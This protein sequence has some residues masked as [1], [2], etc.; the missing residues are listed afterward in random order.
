MK[1]AFVGKKKSNFNVIKMRGTTIKKTYFVSL[2]SG[3]IPVKI[4]NVVTW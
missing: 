2:Y 1:G 4:R 3:T